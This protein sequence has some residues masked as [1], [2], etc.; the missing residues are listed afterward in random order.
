[1]D[2]PQ[3]ASVWLREARLGRLATADAS[4]RPHCVPVC[5]AWDGEG[6]WI[7]LDR[8]P[9]RVDPWRLRRV[10]N[11]LENPRA[12]L[13][14]D[15]WSE[16]WS[17]LGYLLVE[18][19]ITLARQGP[20][21]LLQDKYPQYRSLEV[22]GYL[23]LE[24][25][26]FRAWGSGEGGRRPGE[27]A[28]VVRGRRSVRRFRPDPVSDEQ[29][30]ALL[31][32][33]R[34]APSPHGVQPWRFGVIRRAETRERLARE[35][36]CTWREQLRLDGQDPAV[37]EAR[38]AASQERLR[39]APVLL[40]L[41]LCLEGLERYPDAGRQAAETTMAVQSLGAAA[42]NILLTAWEMGLDAGWMCAPLFCPDTVRRVLAL[43]ETLIPQAL[44][45]VGYAAADP[46][47]RPHRP[48]EELIAFAEWEAD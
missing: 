23:H 4:G 18:G 31:E 43:P 30:R 2:L 13:L 28:A 3:E 16:D 15:R 45:P 9:K 33:A 42:Q 37:I 44:L 17:A 5:F 7:P 36:A 22:L 14:L 29:V 8:K 38:L 27:L 6:V 35:M 21:P 39:Q 46:R 19:R 47:R 10:R 20:L 32:A 34:W 24:I 11:V 1:L 26:R 12:A 25:Q 40:L 41:C 48:A